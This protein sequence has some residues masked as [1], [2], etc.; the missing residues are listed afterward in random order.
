MRKEDGIGK[1]V[2]L[3][4]AGTEPVCLPEV[5]VDIARAGGKVLG[6]KKGAEVEGE[7]K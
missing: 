5:V 1:E 6:M 7:E 2:V 3:E 4:K